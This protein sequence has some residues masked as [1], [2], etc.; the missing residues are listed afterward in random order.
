MA[1]GEREQLQSGLAVGLGVL[2]GWQGGRE[3]PHL[4]DRKHLCRAG[5]ESARNGLGGP[6][7]KSLLH[8]TQ[9]FRIS[10]ILQEPMN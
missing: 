9:Q 4:Y 10:F 2:K 5:A 7:A 8:A 6:G 3:A 1:G